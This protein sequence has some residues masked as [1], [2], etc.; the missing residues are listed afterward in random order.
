MRNKTPRHRPHENSE[1]G[2]T[3][4]EVMIAMVI[5]LIISLSLMGVV[6][7]AIAMNNRNKI[8]STGAMLAQSVVEQIKATVIGTGSSSLTDCTG[9]TFTINTAPGGAALNGSLID[10]TETSPPSNYHMTYVVQSPCT[11]S[12]LQPGTYDVRWNVSI[13]GAPLA[14]TNTYLITVGA[15]LLNHSEG[16]L[17]YPLAVNFRVMAGN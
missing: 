8:G 12:G 3:L 15:R 16:N 10:F 13:V 11:T 7:T 5:L 9:T 14:P 6:T 2:A 1:V 17:I 4:V